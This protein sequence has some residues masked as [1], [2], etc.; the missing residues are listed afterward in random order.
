M[1]PSIYSNRQLI[2]T[3]RQVA[4]GT[5]KVHPRARGDVV[6]VQLFPDDTDLIITCFGVTH[7]LRLLAAG[8]RDGYLFVFI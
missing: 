4:L 2:A 6:L 1:H 5:C 8:T 7:D 3:C